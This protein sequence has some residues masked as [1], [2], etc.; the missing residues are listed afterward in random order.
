[1]NPGV[2]LVVAAVAGIVAALVWR[3]RRWPPGASHDDPPAQRPGLE[4]PAAV[5]PVA[6]PPALPDSPAACAALLADDYQASA[7]PRDLEGNPVFVQGVGLLLAPEV[8]IQVLVDY[9]VGPSGE[10]ACMA[11]AAL[12]RR[13][14]AAAAVPRLMAHAGMLAVWVLY[15]VLRALGAHS[16]DPVIWR[17]LLRAAEWWPRNPLLAGVLD[18]FIAINLAEG[19]APDLPSA[20]AEVAAPDLEALVAVLN[21][22]SGPG[23]EMLRG[24]YN[25]WR[26]TRLDIDYLQTIGRMLPTARD[27][28][29]VVEYEAVQEALEQAVAAVTASPPASFLVIGDPGVGK[30]AFIQLFARRLATRGWSVFEA[31]ASDVQAGQSYMGELEKRMR[32]LFAALES[33]RRV[34]W[35]VP[36]LHELH[37]A[38]KHRYSPVSVL[39][40]VLP[41]I[42]AGRVCLVGES[43]AGAIERLLVERPRL[44]SA[45]KSIGMAP[46]DGPAALVLAQA[47]V[48]A[49]DGP[50]LPLPVLKEALDLSRH[51]LSHHALP[52]GLLDLV[53]RARASAASAGSGTV[54]HAHLVAALVENSGL[55]ADVID[56]AAGLDVAALR[57]RFAARVLGQP[58]AVDCLIDRVA[59]LKAG[60][61]D[62][63]RPVGVFLFAGP[64]GTGKTEVAKVLAE[65]L[66]GSVDRMIRL[67]MSELQDLSGMERIL[68]ESGEGSDADSLVHRIRKQP[69]SLVL[70]DEF[71]K[72][73]PRVWD[74]FLQVFDDGRLTD[75]R[76]NLADFRHAIIILTSNLGGVAHAATSLGFSNSA[77]VFAEAQ[78]LRAI[79]STFRPEFINR[80]DR[81][82]VFRPLSRLVMRDILRK[83]LRLVL[84]RRGF[85]NR[86]WAVEWEE[87]AIEFLLDRGFTPDMGARPLRRAIEQY[88]LGPIAKTI[89]E[90]RFP[91]GDQFLF[92]RSDGRGVQVEFVD[93]DA[94]PG[95][96]PDSAIPAD[97]A[98]SEHAE[99]TA[100]SHFGRD[101]DLPR[102]SAALEAMEAR[103][104][105]DEWRLRKKALLDAMASAQFWRDDNRFDELD[106]VERMDRID[107]AIQAA[108]SLHR[109]VE[110]RPGARRVSPEGLLGN[111]AERLHVLRHAIDDLDAH[112]AS[113][114]FVGIEAVAAED[115]ASPEVW[116]RRVAR[117]YQGWGEARRM[118]V[119][120]LT[121][122]AA[123]RTVLAV[124]GFGVHGILGPEAGLHVFEVPD[125]KGGFERATAR[126]LV[127]AQPTRQRPA[128]QTALEQALACFVAEGGAPATI[129]RRYREAPSPLV[130]D[131]LRGWRTGRLD[132]VL[133][134]DFDLFG[135]R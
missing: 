30:T 132:Q 20:L 97:A 66:F 59:M 119:Q 83:E 72:A 117:M 116:I 37:Y 76:G 4:A 42:E 53:Q 55:P 12:A 51:Y 6:P 62:P 112:R 8:P 68:G 5:A 22:L 134:G 91:E 18:D 102:L 58:D 123:G 34:V 2:W 99:D 73:H 63:H 96:D 90:N 127:V 95:V 77:G 56:D 81:V 103:V 109:R 26:R 3:R 48:A 107:A 105:S 88:V 44:R 98:D 24:Q 36:R 61:T 54:S 135:L 57:A 92:V 32:E 113:E 111:L 129:V 1:M 27:Q 7:H 23:G 29:V 86:A 115:A 45:F 38:G 60:L 122:R 11:G 50:V 15:F 94:P 33:G 31:S 124:G 9:C 52:G 118:R 25:E 126:V 108:R 40:L 133:E 65:F 46:L 69:F 35:Y 79:T 100:P 28:G 89:V 114:V 49:V 78:V 67:D 21:G 13:E 70:L 74:L 71:E 17:V 80:I 125:G 39:D 64:T 84:E 10:L 106:Q 19:E 104:G 120:Q 43:S 75:A 110:P 128:N 130:R 101:V 131:S 16:R 41:E 14:D 121:D 87:S 47:V 85:R 93:P 82:V